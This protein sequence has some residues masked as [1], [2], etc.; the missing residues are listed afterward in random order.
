MTVHGYTEWE[1]GGGCTALGRVIS[2]KEDQSFL[3]IEHG[4]DAVSP[5]AFPC[6][7]YF[8][9]GGTCYGPWVVESEDKLPIRE[10][11]ALTDWTIPGKEN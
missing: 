1:T 8:D 10:A 4:G 5:K 7:L 3:L 11:Q 2:E 6:D 9:N